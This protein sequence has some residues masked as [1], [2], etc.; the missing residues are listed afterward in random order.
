MQPECVRLQSVEILHE[1]FDQH[2]IPK[3][4]KIKHIILKPFA[5]SLLLESKKIVN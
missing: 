4:T 5:S 3:N 1:N 2:F